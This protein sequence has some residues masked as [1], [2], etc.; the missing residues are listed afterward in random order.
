MTPN[1]NEQLRVVAAAMLMKDGVVVSLP[2]PARHHT[3]I[4]HCVDV[5]GYAAPINGRDSG[6][7]LSDG[8][9]CDRRKSKIIASAANQLL[10][11]ASTLDELF[12]EDVW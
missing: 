3:I 1:S 6:F 8:S 12:S 4:R 5:L 7:I 10:P 9:Y 11:R 2:P